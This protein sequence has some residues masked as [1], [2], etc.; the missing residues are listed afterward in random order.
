MA[1]V[2][3]QLLT[4]TSRSGCLKPTEPGRGVVDKIFA[5]K[6][7]F[8]LGWAPSEDGAGTGISVGGAAPQES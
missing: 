8:I 7:V 2:I 1:N 4:G 5:L 3:A 6:E